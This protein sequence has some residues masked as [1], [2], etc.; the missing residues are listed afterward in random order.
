ML[1]F[2]NQVDHYLVLKPRFKLEIEHWDAANSIAW[3][4]AIVH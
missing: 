2:V 4:I 3:R 1:K